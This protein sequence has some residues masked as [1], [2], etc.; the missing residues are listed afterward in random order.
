M[1]HLHDHNY[2]LLLPNLPEEI[3]VDVDV[4][5]DVDEEVNSKY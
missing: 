3:I 5:V 4:D 1:N 2:V